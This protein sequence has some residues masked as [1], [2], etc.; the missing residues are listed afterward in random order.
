M[1]VSLGDLET[2]GEVVSWG[3]G[4]G[5]VMAGPPSLPTAESVPQ[6]IAAELGEH[7]EC[8]HYF[9]LPLTE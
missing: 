5:L 1:V 9:N 8:R 3:A 4:E 2:T 7:G 6:V